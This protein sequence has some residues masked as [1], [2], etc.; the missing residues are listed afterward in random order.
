MKLCS[1]KSMVRKE[2]YDFNFRT[3]NKVAA[4][5]DYDV[6][7]Q[8]YVLYTKQSQFF[9]AS[10]NG[11]PSTDLYLSVTANVA[12]L[13]EWHMRMTGEADAPA[14]SLHQAPWLGSNC[15]IITIIRLIITSILAVSFAILDHRD[16]IRPITT[17]KSVVGIVELEVGDFIFRFHC[18]HN[19]RMVIAFLILASIYNIDVP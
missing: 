7:T 10:K 14:R 19:V 12:S 9:R 2:I 17:E 4:N 16:L 18:L 6:T 1:D 5:L 3:I 11:N 13:F 8:Y 15:L